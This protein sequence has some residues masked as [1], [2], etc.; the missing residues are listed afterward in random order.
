M[1]PILV[2]DIETIADLNTGK[3]LYPNL[4][5][6]SD[7]DA[8]TALIALREAQVGNS[9]MAPPLHEVVCFSYLWLGNTIHLGSFS[10]ETMTEAQIL[11]RVLN[12]FAKKPIAISWNGA[13]FDLP[14][15]LYRMTHHKM[16]AGVITHAGFKQK[17]YLDRYSQVHLDMMDK[18]SFGNW[19]G[20]HK[21]D[22][23]ASLCGFAGKGDTTG[24]DVL[25]M[26]QQGQWQKLTTYCESDVLNTYLLYLRYQLLNG[27]ISLTDYDNHCT[28]LFDYIK[29]LTHDDGTPRHQAFLAGCGHTDLASTADTDT[30][31]DTD[32][33]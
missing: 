23:M 3:R 7:T 15:L 8:M 10:Q 22:V 24:E 26:V 19:H 21:L 12:A 20:K 33:I 9:F 2:F 4:A 17:N 13:S 11:G 29:Q 16:N 27:A 31:T 28:T 6:L 14:V 30:D 5:N 18:F 32:T 25:P 1:T